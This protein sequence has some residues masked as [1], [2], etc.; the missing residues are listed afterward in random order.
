MKGP[1]LFRGKPVEMDCLTVNVD[2]NGLEIELFEPHEVESPWKEFL[3]TRG[4]GI[5]HVCFVV[6]DLENKVSEY[7][8]QGA[9]VLLKAEWD[10]GGSVYLDFKTGGLVVELLQM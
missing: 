10:G 1:V 7:T 6:E 5:H 4:E 2:F 8:G 3:D 9:E